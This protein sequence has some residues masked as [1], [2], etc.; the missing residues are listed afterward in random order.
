MRIHGL[1]GRIDIAEIQGRDRIDQ[2]ADFRLR[3]V[4]D[5]VFRIAS[6]GIAHTDKS[7][8]GKQ[9]KTLDSLKLN[10][11]I[12]HPEHDGPFGVFSILLFLALLHEPGC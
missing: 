10:C 8:I 6:R 11:F 3:G 12:R 7:R 1:C 5:R 2:D 4:S 9:T